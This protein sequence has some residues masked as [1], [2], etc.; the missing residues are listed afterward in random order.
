MRNNKYKNTNSVK[1]EE[2]NAGELSVALLHV[3]AQG[4]ITTDWTPRK[5]LDALFQGKFKIVEV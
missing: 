3:Q 1:I 2:V 5:S 4:S